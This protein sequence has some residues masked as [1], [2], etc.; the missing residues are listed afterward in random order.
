MHGNVGP[1]S[2][3][4]VNVKGGCGKST[5]SSNLASYYA[6]RGD[7]VGL[8]DLD[9]Q[10]SG[11]RWLQR[12]SQQRPPISGITGWAPHFMPELDYLITDPPAQMQR[13]DLI[14]LTTRADVVVIPVLPSPIDIQAAADFIRDLLI[15]AK[16]RAT[17]K[18]VA[19]VANRVRTNT[20]IFDEL[21]KFLSALDIPFIATLRDT[22]NYIHAASRGV[23]VFEMMPSTTARDREQWAP[24][25][26]WIERELHPL[27]RPPVSLP[28]SHLTVVR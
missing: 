28:R 18:A 17:G 13:K 22:Q 1:K 7:R 2:I 9:R 25:V 14:T 12:R 23:G 16:V 21:K 6:Q 11:I 27:Q 4:V 15:Y 20:L 26:E 3:L 19:V 5:L 24:L 8:L 10:M